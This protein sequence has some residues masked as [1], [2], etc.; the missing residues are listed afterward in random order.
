[1]SFAVVL[2][3]DNSFFFLYFFIVFKGF[4]CGFAVKSMT[5]SKNLK[6]KL[7]LCG[8]ALTSFLA[9]NAHSVVHA[10]T[11]QGDTDSNA[12]TWD[13]DQD[14][15]KVVNQDSEQE[16]TAQ[17]ALMQAS[18]TKSVQAQDKS[19]PPAITKAMPNHAERKIARQNPV[20]TSAVNQSNVQK[21]RNKAN[22][23]VA[24]VHDT[25]QMPVQTQVVAKFS[26]DSKTYLINIDN[27]DSTSIEPGKDDPHYTVASDLVGTW[28]GTNHNVSGASGGSVNRG[29]DY[30][31][32]EM[33]GEIATGESWRMQ[34]LTDTNAVY[35][36]HRVGILIKPTITKE[37]FLEANGSDGYGTYG[38]VA[39]RPAMFGFLPY[40]GSYKSDSDTKRDQQLNYSYV[41]VPVDMNTGDV[42]KGLSLV[43]TS[44][45][46]G[47]VPE[48]NV[49]KEY[50]DGVDKYTYTPDTDMN[51]GTVISKGT[52]KADQSEVLPAVKQA[53]LDIKSGKV[54]YPTV[55]HRPQ[56]G[57]SET[58]FNI[59]TQN[60]YEWV[61]RFD[62]ESD[63]S[64]PEFDHYHNTMLPAEENIAYLAVQ[65]REVNPQDSR[66]HRSVQRVIH[67]AFPNGKKPA[68]Y[69]NITDSAGNRLTFDS[70]NNLTQIVTFT[71]S[72]VE[73]L[74]DGSV[75]W[76]S[77]VQHGA[78]NA[79]TL[80]AIPGYTMTQTK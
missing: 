4:K 28:W 74:G 5:Q 77:W 24:T 33:N 44:V 41:A 3:I 29:I 14:D 9:L 39:L 12:I 30:N 8:L 53:I 40:A 32:V 50:V 54:K 70:D 38:W 52:L 47:K 79:V 10:D 80:P 34:F 76:N 27:P 75:Q 56:P 72:G 46:G 49:N 1:M 51:S 23:K 15:S 65:T 13:S 31:Q 60:D 69:D 36:G 42:I 26:Q 25:A 57:Q 2:I 71:R 58:D 67:V 73:N 16:K 64:T 18:E 7:S 21:Q 43:G 20:Q 35:Q 55:Y 17:S 61:N 11:V 63:G 45:N 37:T 48:W 78:I 66:T 59:S 22:V 68:S 6:L 62:T 19:V